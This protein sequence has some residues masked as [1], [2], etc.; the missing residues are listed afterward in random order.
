MKIQ[1]F[2]SFFKISEIQYLLSI[3]NFNNFYLKK[4]FQKK[5][6]KIQIIFPYLNFKKF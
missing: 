3:Y 1:N 2:I 5:N 6:E 4:I